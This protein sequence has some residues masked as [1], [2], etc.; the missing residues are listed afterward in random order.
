MR[1]D[2]QPNERA[3][4]TKEVAEEVGIATTTV[5]RYGQLLEQNGYEF[6]KDGDRRIFVKSDVEALKKIRDT[7]LPK[8][9][10]A[11]EIVKEQQALLAG[12]ETRELALSD[13]YDGGIQ[14]SAQMKEMFR[15]L[16]SEL[17]AS[18]EMNVQLQNDMNELKTTVAR[19]K[20]DHH[21]ISSGVGN[22]SQKTHTKMDK[23]MQQQ[24]E[25]YEELLNQEK[26]KS[27]FLQKE[28]QE[29]REEQKKEWR[30]QNDFNHRLEHSVKHG[31]GAFERI[32]SLFRK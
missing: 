30:A 20:Q 25:Q 11:K 13:T 24:K 19:L 18:R 17:A 28:I 6:F 32:L 27:E 2:I 29:M 16:A 23:M 14:D 31:K 5:R 21:V 15:F 8:E 26:E 7:E 12:Y 1:H 4:S 9:D 10:E 3:F 22:F